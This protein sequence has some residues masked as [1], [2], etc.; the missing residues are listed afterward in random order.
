MKKEY[1]T[2]IV[3]LVSLEVKWPVLIAGSPEH[4]GGGKNIPRPRRDP[5]F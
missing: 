2:P 4:G 1:N 3:E 5:A